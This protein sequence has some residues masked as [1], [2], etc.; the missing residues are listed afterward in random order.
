MRVCLL[1]ME[2]FAWGKHGGYGRATRII[3]RELVRRGVEVS[4]VVPLRGNQRPVEQLD[5]IHVL[6]FPPRAP[7]QAAR[8]I[9]QCNADIYHS[10]EPSFTTY[11]AQQK[12][13][14]G[15]HLVTLRD[16]HDR[17]DW[18]AELRHPSLNR[19][20]V[21]ANKLFEDNPLVQRAV[22]RAHRVYCAAE[23]LRAKAQRKY[24]LKSIPEFLPTPVSVPHQVRKAER[25]TVCYLA[26]WDR[27]K[28]PELFL[29]LARHFP[30]IRFI[31]FGT[32]RDAAY[33][34][35]LR[36][37][38]AGLPNLEMPG[39]VDQFASGTVASTLSESWILV[40]TSVREGLP[41]SFLEAAGHG[42]AILSAV[43]PDGFASRFGAK[44][45]GDNFAGGLET[46]LQ[47]DRWRGCGE[48]AREHARST[49][50]LGT[51]ID[52]HLAIYNEL[53]AGQPSAAGSVH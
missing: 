8:L 4:A 53:L 5:G 48:R 21:L 3:G 24:R 27:R 25:P 49:F 39:H 12:M 50:E 33:E 2:I 26:R 7:W 10:Q 42:C 30:Q 23:F 29:A 35:G 52:R 41:N 38:Y 43:D 47:G 14:G 40:N 13:P 34:R 31:A 45:E 1:S 36:A 6:G 32:S 11:L 37:R 28:R 17:S 46:L 18:L 19:G 22:R 9:R 15:K 51:A 44:V 20:Q 16:T